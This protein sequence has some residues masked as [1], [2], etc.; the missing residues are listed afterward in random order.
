MLL[1]DCYDNQSDSSRGANRLLV[2]T[3]GNISSSTQPWSLSWVMKEASGS[4]LNDVAFFGN[5]DTDANVRMNLT[6][7]NALQVRS[8]NGTIYSP[9][10]LTHPEPTGSSIITLDTRESMTHIAITYEALNQ[11]TSSLTGKTG[12]MNFY[13]NGEHIGQQWHYLADTADKYKT[14]SFAFNVI[15]HWGLVTSN[16]IGYTGS[17]GQIRFY[18]HALEKSE[19]D[20][21]YRHPHLRANR[22]TE[23]EFGRGR[24]IMTRRIRS[25][26]YGLYTDL[27]AFAT[28]HSLVAA[29]YRDDPADSSYYEGSKLTAPAINEASLDDVDGEEI[30][31]VTVRNR[32]SLIYKKDLP[33]GGNLDVR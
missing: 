26:G 12:S 8:A 5:T 7:G 1:F 23:N 17:L 10:A 4:N 2:P 20:H 18:E 25:N 24:E 22:D 33:E 6:N 16:T 21:L 28:S 29:D 27:G 31:K 30:V 32:Y 15:G 11:G 19:I 14:G 13:Y 9:R 3:F